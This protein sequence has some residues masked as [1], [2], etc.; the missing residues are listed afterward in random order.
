MR[1]LVAG[2]AFALMAGAALA[3]TETGSDKPAEPEFAGVTGVAPDDVL[4]VRES[5]GADRPIVGALSPFASGVEVLERREDWA[6]VRRGE[7]EGWVADR[8][9][10]PAGPSDLAGDAPPDPLICSG[11]EP[12]W[13][14]RFDGDTA[15]YAT[16][17]GEEPPAAISGRRHSA[18][19]TIVWSVPFGESRAIISHDRLCSDGMSDNL[20]DLSV[21]LV[22]PD[23]AFLSG[24]CRRP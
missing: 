11:T 15:V 5:P 7:V 10:G 23:G 19:S 9:L 12:F 20:Y 6:R 21:A 1:R 18:N 14:V 16:P 17:E 24:C 3:G 13:S 2:L 8:Y 4:N 22:R